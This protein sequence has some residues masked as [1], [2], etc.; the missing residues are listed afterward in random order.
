[1]TSTHT[2]RLLR[3]LASAALALFLPAF[4]E[5]DVII[6]LAVNNDGAGGLPPTDWRKDTAATGYEAWVGLKSANFSL[7]KGLTSAPNQTP[8]F[9]AAA[10]S[11]LGL[12]KTLDR[13]SPKIFANVASASTAI[14]FAEIH[15]VESGT[16]PRTYLKIKL[17]GVYFSLIS[18]AAVEGEANPSENV[19][20]LFRKMTFTFVPQTGAPIVGSYDQTAP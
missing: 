15:F 11:G 4:A 16:T 14:P 18:T 7:Y 17:E 2:S 19:E 3:W 5:A 20:V 12:I 13:I 1:M 8:T 10:F 9:T 6:Y